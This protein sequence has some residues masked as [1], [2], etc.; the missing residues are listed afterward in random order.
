MRPP[1]AR[2]SVLLA[3]T[4]LA[5]G[6]SAYASTYREARAALDEGR[7]AEAVAAAEEMLATGPDA[8][9]YELLSLA[10]LR[11]GRQAQAAW[12]L[13]NAAALGGTATSAAVAEEVYADL[14]I[15]L[16]PLPRRGLPATAAWVTRT[17]GPNAAALLALALGLAGFGVLAWWLL[18]RGSNSRLGVAGATLLLLATCCLYLAFRQNALAHPREAVVLAEAVLRDAPADAAPEQRTLPPGA[19]VETGE[20]LSGYLAVVLPTGERGWL[21]EGEMR[22]VAPLA[23]LP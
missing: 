8:A 3:V 4:A 17:L 16:R 19:V 10:E 1:A 13:R 9:T 18:R 2:S 14:S 7:V 20:A 11:R 22:S 5:I 6:T 23:V 12:A 15:G 21:R